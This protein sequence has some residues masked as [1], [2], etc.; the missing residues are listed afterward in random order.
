MSEKDKSDDIIEISED[1]ILVQDDGESAVG[2]AVWKVLIVDDDE[3]VHASTR[4]ALNGIEI[5]E[6]P[7]VFLHAYSAAEARQVVTQHSD[8]AVILLDVVMETDHAGLE[9][10]KYI[11]DEA[12]ILDTR[13][14][15]R[16]G[17]PGYA[18]ELDVISQY[19]INDYRTKSELTRARLV[20]ALT[21]SIRSYRQISTIEV[22]KLKLISIVNAVTSILEQQ[23]VEFFGNE[24]IAR[25]AEFL[26]IK[27]S[28]LLVIRHEGESE[29]SVIGATGSLYSY[30]DNFHHFISDGSA[31]SMVRKVLSEQKSHS[32][33]E[34]TT[35]Y[36]RSK[37]IR[38]AIY[39]PCV[40]TLE[41]MDP[42]LLDVFTANVAIGLANLNLLTKLNE[43]AY[44][45]ELC[46]IPNRNACLRM[47]EQAIQD[48]DKE[49]Q[50]FL[51][52]IHHFTDIND[53]LGQRVGNMLLQEVALRLEHGVRGF[54][55]T[56]RVAAD[57][58][59]V[60]AKDTVT[61]DMVLALFEEP[62]MVAG[63]RLNVVVRIGVC[64]GTI[65]VDDALAVL[66]YANIALNRAKA[67]PHLMW[68][69]YEQSMLENTT[70]RIR[71]VNELKQALASRQLE[72]WYQPQLSLDPMEVIGVEA[73]LRWR[74]SGSYVSPAIFIPLAEYSGLIVDIGAWVMRQA[75]NTLKHLQKRYDMRMAVNVSMPQF[76]QS[77]FI[78]LVDGIIK[79][80]GIAP[81]L[82][83]LE[84]TESIA[85]E[86]PD[87]VRD[88]LQELNE[89]GVS[90]AIDDFGTGYSSLS[91]LQTLAIDRLKIDRAFV[92]DIDEGKHGI[93][94]EMILELGKKLSLTVVA[95]GVETPEQE[96]FLRERHC[97]FVQ[98]FKY[99]KPM[100][101][102]ELD[103]WLQTQNVVV[104]RDS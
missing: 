36:V 77:N 89:L 66:N 18:P 4:F 15:L 97:D 57:V 95:E 38:A 103:T 86:D 84:I 96:A 47:L 102:E 87:L 90:V 28:G 17:Q 43:M 88:K 37:N 52:D 23:S 72:L 92:I 42:Q 24:V 46:K 35:V 59:A 99:A 98:G 9:L 55:Q 33:G 20:T 22:T 26:G 41:G 5:L 10:V 80:S 49:W 78:E 83:E 39:F 21:A 65:Q 62:I 60:I 76:R 8:L 31:N 58:F 61:P 56:S 81:E 73:L 85:M 104:K 32:T 11:R 12:R 1:D 16:T 75:A 50:L 91:Y 51:I 44:F 45:D 71:I 74:H 29:L 94:A 68:A 27:N 14:I 19:D 6:R 7:I 100:P 82:F 48:K 63:N 53:G 54:V 101:V 79:D 93:I 25:L 34:S 70:E 13:I 64:P 69:C 67:N 40:A 2:G 30:L 3:Q